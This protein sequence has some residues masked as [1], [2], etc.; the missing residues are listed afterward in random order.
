LTRIAVV[1]GQG[2]HTAQTFALVDLLGDGNKYL[3]MIG[4]LDRLT[5]KKIRIPGRILPVLPPRLLP[6]DS[7]LMAVLRTILT[8]M[9]SFIYFL[10]FRPRAVIS[11][12]TGLTVPIFYSA[13]LFGMK[14]VFIESMSR[15]D[16]LSITGRLL[17]GK[18]DLF[19]VQ[20][21]E[22]AEQTKGAVY[23]G[24]LL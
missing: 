23:G 21:P 10:A 22:L 1:L 4:L 16:T 11:C 9:M 5:P 19:M 17:L 18:T 14:T 24:Q 12:G 7:R 13:R 15:V 20:W 6:Q 3:Y 8:F 2:G